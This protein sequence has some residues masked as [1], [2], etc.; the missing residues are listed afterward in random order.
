MYFF[1]LLTPNNCCPLS[2]IQCLTF[3]IHFFYVSTP[4][5]HTSQ[6]VTAYALE[7]NLR[8]DGF[9]RGKKVK[10]KCL[11]CLWEVKSRIVQQRA[12]FL[13]LA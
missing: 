3:L 6:F 10:K 4:V 8:V 11:N 9:P 5:S 12:Y 13:G 2:S 7:T 1:Y